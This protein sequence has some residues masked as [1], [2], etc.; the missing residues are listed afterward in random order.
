[1]I[2]SAFTTILMMVGVITYLVEREYFGARITIMRNA[3]SF[4]IAFVVTFLTG[5]FRMILPLACLSLMLLALPAALRAQNYQALSLAECLDLAREQNPVLGGAREKVKEL[6]ADYDAARSKFFPRLALLSYSQWIDPNRLSS[7]GGASTQNLFAREGL[8]SLTSKQIVF[9]GLK[10]YYNTDAARLGRQAQQQEVART[11]DEVAYQVKEAFYR[12]L[13]AKEN[14]QVV[15]EALKER[16]EFLKITDAFFHAGKATRLDAFRAKSQTLEA[17]QAQVEAENAVRLAREILTRTLGLEEKAGMDIQGRLPE[18]FIPAAEFNSLW[19]QVEQTNPEIKM[20]KLE[21]AQSQALIKASQ[22]GYFP[23]VSLQ[24]NVGV[25]HHDIGGTKD[26][27]LGGVF[28][29]FP[30]FEG[31][32]T[33]AQVAKVSSQY[34]QMQEKLRERVNALRVDLMTGWNEQENARKGVVTSRQNVATN[35]EAYAS[36]LSLYRTDKAIGL[37]V[38]TAQVELTRSRLSLISYQVA[39]EIGQ[40]KVEQIVGGEGEASMAIKQKEG[41]EK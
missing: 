39:Y 17:E 41:E 8:T 34:Q 11:A 25:R 10:T 40:A 20:L 23:E 28:M 21:L 19:N 16:R 7:G 37:D 5:I 13:E 31:G 27:W 32:L 22:A 3:I 36:A 9:D 4:F 33:R 14:L 24:G 38:L 1:M 26:E 15:A 2:I 29:E 12:L 30:F 18:E 35:E 6:V